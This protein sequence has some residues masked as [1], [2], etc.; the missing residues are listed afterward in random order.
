M[1]RYLDAVLIRAA[2]HPGGI[3][4]PG[5]PDLADGTG[6]NV[7]QWRGWLERVW[8]RASFADAIAVA[9]PVLAREV[10]KV[11]DGRCRDPRQI[12]R[13]AM[14]VARYVL[15]MIG[16]STPFALFAG[17]AAVGLGP[18]ALA[19]WGEGHR[20]VVRPAGAWLAEVVT[21]LETCPE[22]VRCLPVVANNL[23]VVRGNRL[24][25]PFQ[26]RAGDRGDRS[27]QHDLVDVSVRHTRAVEAVMR[28][29]H[30]PVVIGD[31]VGKLTGDFPAISGAVVERMLLELV[32]LRVLLTGL[33]PPMTLPD[34]LGH[35]VAQ[36]DAVD[37]EAIPRVADWVRELRA[38]ATTSPATT[39]R[40]CRTIARSS[41]S[42][43]PSRCV[44]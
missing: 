8:S 34:A 20:P 17:V 44:A 7:E 40:R 27:D 38:I 39:Q 21:G 23:C 32:K 41:A 26:Q 13:T 3:D 42:A 30:S 31:L 22:L 24:T 4:L 43:W 29:A 5:W 35:V 18:D 19:R 9:S 33:R 6:G 1:Y 11:C 14:S 28:Y 36:L 25:V 12:R 10:R 2:T 37:A 16:R 15:R